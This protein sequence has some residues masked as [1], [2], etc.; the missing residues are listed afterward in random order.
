M[1]PSSEQAAELVPPT[2]GITYRIAG[3]ARLFA[4]SGYA[5]LLQVMHPSVGAGVTQHSNFK[6]EPWGR[7]LRTLDYTSALV[8]GGPEL[9]WRMGRRVRAMHKR[10]TGLRPDGVRYHALEPRP[11]AWVHAS[12]A[13]A[14]IRG[15]H[16]YCGPLTREAIEEF[17][18]EWRRMGRLIGLRYGDLPESWPALIAYFDAMVERELEDNEAAQDVLGALRDPTA[19]PVSWMPDTVWRVLRWPPT[20][21]GWLAT[22]GMLPPVLRRRLGVGWGV[23][24]ERLFRLLARVMRASRPLMPPPARSF[25]PHYLRWRRKTIA[26]DDASPALLHRRN[27][28]TVP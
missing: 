27:N 14:I 24:R 13:E 8:Y 23:E 5:L 18:F 6:E 12:L 15:H 21:T 3:D 17:W 22:V 2:G 10:I 7:L 9:A 4:G 25:G 28:P 11:Y 19:P 20:K 26:R 1:M 16:L